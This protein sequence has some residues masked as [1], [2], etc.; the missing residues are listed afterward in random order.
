VSRGRDARRKA[1]RQ[2][3]RASARAEHEP[4]IL[5]SRLVRLVPAAII[6]AALLAVAALGI[7]AGGAGNDREQ[8]QREVAALLKGIPQD[9]AILGWQTAP[10][11]LLVFA[12]I[13]CPTVKRFVEAHLPSIITTWVRNGSVKL[14]YRSLRTD[15]SDERVF[16]RQEIATQAAGRQGKLWNF[17]LTFLHEQGE[18]RTNYATDDFLTDVASQVPDLSRPRWHRDRAD[19]LLSK[20]VARNLRFAAE[21]DLKYTPSFLIAFGR[22]EERSPIDVSDSIRKEVE[23]SL[24]ATVRALREEAAG[25]VPTLGIFGGT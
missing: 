13:E 8:V 1:K 11:T 12:D 10:I 14:E 22:G 7:S 15:T 9:G 25:D 17:A 2:Q 20:R 5:A 4:V 3:A 21:G 19:P 6:L 18:V 24:G 23:D 16:Y